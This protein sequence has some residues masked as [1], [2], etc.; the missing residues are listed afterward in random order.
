MI[1][2]DEACL[3][4]IALLAKINAAVAEHNA[5]EQAVTT[6]QSELVSKSKVVGQLL[7]EAKKRYPKVADFEAFL[8]CV[9][10]LK[11]SRA[12]DLMR[13]AGGRT[14]DE[15]L[16][17]EARDRQRKSR[18]NK[19]TLPSTKPT[20]AEPEPKPV[21]VTD[22]RV[23][24]SPEI[25]AEERKAQMAALDLADD[26]RAAKASARYLAEFKIACCTYL[27]KITDYAHQM[28]APTFV[29]DTLKRLRA[30]A[31]SRRSAAPTWPNTA[32]ITCR[33][34]P[35]RCNPVATVRRRSWMR[36]GGILVM[37]SSRRLLPE[38]SMNGL[39]P[40]TVNTKSLGPILGN[41]L[42]MARV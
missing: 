20:E 16:R 22:P 2:I 26:L 25:S 9:N 38:K 7:L 23:T 11:L 19:K 42:R 21:S 5:A 36:H 12:Y 15:Q 14:T 10:G 1:N 27:P 35:R 28:D 31:K 34:M 40:V 33:L 8:K 30:E 32:S 3:A 18:T 37:A 17:Q 29:Q 41:C 39:R 6:A 4:K 13:L 24:E